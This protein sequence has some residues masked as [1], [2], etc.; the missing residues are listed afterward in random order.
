M[1]GLG[2]ISAIRKHRAQRTAQRIEQGWQDLGIMDCVQ[3]H[4]R[5]HD[6]VGGRV[7]RQMQLAPDP[8]FVMTMFPDL[9][10]SLTKNLEAGGVDDQVGELALGWQPVSHL[11]YAG[12]LAD[13]GIVGGAQWHIHQLKQRIEQALSCAQG[14][15]EYSLEHQ[16]GADSLVG[17]ERA[18]APPSVMVLMKPVFHRFGIDPEG[19][20]TTL[21]Q[22]LVVLRP[23][24][25]S[26]TRFAHDA[27]VKRDLLI[28]SRVSPKVPFRLN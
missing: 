27:D 28:R 20:R 22:R 18:A 2:V 9:Q 3:C 24:G 1:T 12:A 17:V 23:I 19:K 15:I 13:T 26:V 21:N 14:E 16:E 7:Y 4:L 8:A 6:V 25:N 5:R 11:D 10:L